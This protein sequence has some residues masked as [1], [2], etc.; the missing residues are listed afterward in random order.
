M[1]KEQ[2]LRNLIKE[3]PLILKQIFPSVFCKI[4]FIAVLVLILFK[5]VLE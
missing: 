3:T 5:D 2:I 1:W 4:G